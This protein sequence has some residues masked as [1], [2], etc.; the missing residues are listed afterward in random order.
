V[1]LTDNYFQSLDLYL[2]W[3][4]S[5]AWSITIYGHNLLGSKQIEQRQFSPNSQT[6]QSF[7]LVGRY[8]LARVQWQF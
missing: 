3:S 6:V 8:L 2:K 7:Q 5:S 4:L 1:L